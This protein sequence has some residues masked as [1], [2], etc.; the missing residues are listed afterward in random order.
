MSTRRAGC[1]RSRRAFSP[2]LQPSRFPSAPSLLWCFVIGFRSEAGYLSGAF[3]TS[4]VHHH[5]SGRRSASTSTQFRDVVPNALPWNG[6]RNNP[7]I[8]GTSQRSQSIAGVT[9][10]L[11]LLG[12][13]GSPFSLAQ[14]TALIAQLRSFADAE[15]RALSRLRRSRSKRNFSQEQ[16]YALM[17]LYRQAMP[18]ALASSNPL[19]S[20]LPRLTPADTGSTPEPVNA[21]AVHVSGAT[22]K[23]VYDESTASDL[24]EYQLRGVIGEEWDDDDAVTV[25]TNAP[26]APREFTVDF[27]LTQPGTAIALKVYVVTTSGREKGSATLVVERP[28]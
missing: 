26:G 20:T 10:P 15:T 21:S 5:R 12:P 9:L 8:H 1:S 14:F 11:G 17:K 23:T 4:Y 28:T 18:T 13:E 3:H 22:S 24:K 2:A 19:Q 16:A 25:A 7:C 27:G 6:S